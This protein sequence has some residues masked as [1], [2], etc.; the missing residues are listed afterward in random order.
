VS[1]LEKRLALSRVFEAWRVVPH[2]SLAN[3]VALRKPL[4]GELE[5]VWLDNLHEAALKERM[6]MA[7]KHLPK[8]AHR[9]R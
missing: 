7:R 6:R 8:V 5:D 3:L 1:D 9:V 4:E 2:L